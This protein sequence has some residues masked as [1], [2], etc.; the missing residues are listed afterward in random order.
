MADESAEVQS[1]FDPPQM[2]RLALWTGACGFALTAL[3]ASALSTAGQHRIQEA[4]SR[5]APAPQVVTVQVPQ[6]AVPNQE[7]ADLKDTLRAMSADREKLN[8]RIASLERTLDD[9]TGSIRRIAEK[10]P[11]P[12]KLEPVKEA[13]PPPVI[14]PPAT[15]VAA[16]SPAETPPP[17]VA[18]PHE[19]VPLPPV[20]IASAPE[21][22]QPDAAPAPSGD[23]KMDVGIDMGGASTPEALRARWAAVKA[24]YGPMLGP[25]KAMMAMQ[26]RSP[27]VISYR[28]VIGPLAS[29]AAANALCQKLI[30]ARALCK[31]TSFNPQAA[32]LASGPITR[33]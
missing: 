32:G 20:R 3:V 8:Q 29:P 28:L 31:A 30:A 15:V 23:L 6:P 17:P 21:A 14:A 9:V 12:R 16:A 26:E 5:L 7:L 19:A 1:R 25:L 4:F 24:N 2:R 33:R 18:V 13:A 11:E 27:G 22:Q 10:P